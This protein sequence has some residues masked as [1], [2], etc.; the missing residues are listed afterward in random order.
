M[1]ELGEEKSEKVPVTSEAPGKSEVSGKSEEK[2]RLSVF[3][4]GWAPLARLRHEM[5]RVFDD[6]IERV[7]SFPFGARAF[8]VEPMRGFG[9]MFSA[10]V[11]AIDFAEED[12]RYVLTAELPGLGDKDVELSLVEDVLTIKGE[13]KDER[14]EK[15]AGFRVSE[16]RYGAFR[17]SFRLPDDVDAEKIAASFK[18]GVLTVELP[19]LPEAA[20]KAKKIEIKA[21]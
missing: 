21:D 15:G 13:K 9:R 3:E 10:N 12:N 14:E 20:A 7:P 5:D 17:R 16:R 19:K 2:G 18:K 6:F 8:E 11:P 4:E 1:A